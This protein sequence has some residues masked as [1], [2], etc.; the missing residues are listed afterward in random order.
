M[1]LIRYLCFAC[2]QRPPQTLQVQVREGGSGAATAASFEESGN[3]GAGKSVEMASLSGS[4]NGGQGQAFQQS[5]GNGGGG[6]ASAGG[7]PVFPG[8][9]SIAPAAPDASAA[10]LNDAPLPPSALAPSVGLV[11]SGTG[12]LPL[13]STD[14]SE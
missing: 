6:G 2:S 5:A 14:I 8:A 1:C 11:F 3:A 4:N 12:F 9:L 7:P 13:C 10:A